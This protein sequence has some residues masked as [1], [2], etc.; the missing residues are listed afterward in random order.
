MRKLIFLPICLLAGCATHSPVAKSRTAAPLAPGVVTTETPRPVRFVETRYDVSGYRDPGDP[1]VWHEPHAILRK[2]EVP[3]QP[4]SESLTNGPLTAYVPATYDP[5]PPS[6]ELAAELTE[7]HQI[8]V[9]L[10]TMKANMFALQ[11][12]AQTQYGKL[13]AETDATDRLRQQLAND[14]QA[15]LKNQTADS[16][17]A[18]KAT[19]P[20]W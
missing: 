17:A 7:Q 4:P 12:Q 16:G 13:V 19:T 18:A 11:G 3:G 1:A 15:R 20:D 10:R 5:L 2:T 8:T 14:Q 6:V 9:E